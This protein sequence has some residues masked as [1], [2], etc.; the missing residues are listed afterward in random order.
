MQR[1]KLSFFI[2]LSFVLL[3]R[4]GSLQA[5]NDFP[6]DTS[7]YET[8]PHTVTARLFL[9]Q[10][11]VHLNFPGSGNAPDMEYK[12]NAKLNLGLGITLHGI[13][14]S[15]F[16]GFSFLNKKDE[17]KGKTKGLDVQL[18]VYPKKWAIDLLAI[19]PKGYY[20][21]PKGFAAANANSYYYR[22][23]V[24]LILM[25]LSVYRVPNKEK[26]SY[27]AAIT[28]TEWQKKSAGS[29]LYG[30]QAYYGN[31]KGDSAL[32]PTKVQN[33]YPQA[34]VNKINFFSF[35]PGIGYAY[36]LVIERHFFI[37]GSLVG[38]LDLNFTNEEGAGKNNKV[39]LSPAEVFKTAVGYNSSN[40]NVSVNWTG[41][42]LWFKGPSSSE[43]YFWPTGTY[44]L[45]VAKKFTHKNK[46]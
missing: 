45:V 23:D 15:V 28:Q 8:F 46:K 3:V 22:P 42:G 5:Q 36:T 7:Y 14:A 44:K 16:Y 20:L 6:H 43:N 35:G 17:P 24:K 25:G 12:A 18:H 38:N 31:I 29:I 11:Y 1:C 10:K 41:N 39:A 34:G 26:F 27:R 19:F 13:S 37:T 2:V 9:S 21:D 32:V 40:W 33:S 4:T 30:G